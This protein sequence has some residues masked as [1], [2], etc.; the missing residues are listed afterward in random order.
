MKGLDVRKNI[1]VAVTKLTLGIRVG[2]NN[3]HLT[4]DKL[5]PVNLRIISLP[6]INTKM[7]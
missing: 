1:P 3:S 5:S 6:N 2:F 4:A 7:K